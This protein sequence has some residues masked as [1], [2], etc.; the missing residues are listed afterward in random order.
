MKKHM[1]IFGAHALDAELMGGPAA[2][3]YVADGN[4]AK[5]IHLTRGER[6]PHKDPEQFGP[7]IEIEMQEVAAA[8]NAAAEWM[9]YPGGHFPS[10]ETV[11]ND[12]VKMIRSEKPTVVITHWSGSLHPRH[13]LTHE[14]VNEA[15]KLSEDS[16]YDTGQEPHKVSF[17]FYG[18]NCEDLNGYIPQIYIEIE[19]ILEQ[20][21]GAVKKYELFSGEIANV[22]Y[23]D[24]YRSMATIRAIEAGNQK[25]SKTYMLARRTQHNVDSF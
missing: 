8:M 14:L 25:M 4:T 9:G 19:D 2:I 22:P 6:N 13:T 17:L 23:E 10:N 5:F 18:E 7:Q 12:M 3:K 24:Y 20:W 15:V 21:M 1:I 11:L 16:K